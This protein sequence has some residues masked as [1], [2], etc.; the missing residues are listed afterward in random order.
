MCS[1]MGNAVTNN[2]PKISMTVNNSPN[3]IS[4]SSSSKLK[5]GETP[6]VSFAPTGLN[7]DGEVII[8]KTADGGYR[9]LGRVPNWEDVKID[10]ASSEFKQAQ[11]DYNVKA[12]FYDN[13]QVVVAKGGLYDR[14]KTYKN[15]KDFQKD[16]TKRIES[17]RSLDE[18]AQDSINQ[19]RISQIEAEY[20][21]GI[22]RKNSNAQA[23]KKINGA[24]STDM[25]NIK[26]RLSVA[27]MAEKRL[28]DLIDRSKR[29]GK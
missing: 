26:T 2:A 13:G 1:N 12:S 18:K 20:Y 16:V 4:M 14:A 23:L 27:Y 19:G 15:R 22:V 21:R 6:F 25:K 8:A 11:R 28:N 29:L 9:Y 3:N 17:K 10:T 7:P 24:I 5:K